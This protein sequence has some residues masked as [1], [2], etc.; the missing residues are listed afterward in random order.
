MNTED[1]SKVTAPGRGVW[2]DGDDVDINLFWSFCVELSVV[3]DDL[4]VPSFVDTCVVAEPE[5]IGDVVVG[6]G[7]TWV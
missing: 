7:T 3:P 1:V 6:S 5:P 4:T 2:V